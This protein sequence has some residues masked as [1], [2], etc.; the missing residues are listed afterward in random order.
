MTEWAAFDMDEGIVAGPFATKREVMR[1]Y[2]YPWV[3]STRSCGGYDVRAGYGP[4]DFTEVFVCTFD[5]ARRNGF[6]WAIDDHVPCPEG[7]AKD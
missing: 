4:E 6:G 7:P 2:A 5:V 3:R 1:E